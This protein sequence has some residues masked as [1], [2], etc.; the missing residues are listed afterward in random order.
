MELEALR[1]VT[2]RGIIYKDGKI[3]AQQLTGKNQE[4][5]CTPGGGV[6][7]HESLTDGLK[8][9]IYEETGIKPVIG[10]LLF[11]QQFPTAEIHHGTDEHLEFFFHIE[12]ADDY[13]T[14][15]LEKTSH[16]VA[17]VEHCDFIN[18]QKEN[19][20]PAFLQTIDVESYVTGD[21]PVYFYSEL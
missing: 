21:K 20:L 17:E 3:F 4:Y 7:S 13:H 19:I 10:K 6:D 1:R 12:N 5:W 11:V 18:P 8:R 2:V 15:D 16:G 9:E 14:I